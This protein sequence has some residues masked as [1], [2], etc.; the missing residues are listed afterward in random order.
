MVLNNNDVKWFRPLWRRVAATGFLAL[1]LGWEVFFM[2]D[3]FWIIII[4]AAFVFALYTLFYAFPKEQPHDALPPAGSP[5][6]Q[7]RQDP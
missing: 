4:G 2:G 7:D 6:S 1:W 3:T 5:D